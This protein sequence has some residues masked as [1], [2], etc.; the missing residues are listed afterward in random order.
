MN[1]FLKEEA[2]RHGDRIVSSV[3]LVDLKNSIEQFSQKHELNGFQ[4]WINN[5]LYNYNT[6][7]TDFV[8][9]SVICRTGS[10]ETVVDENNIESKG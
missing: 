9:K 7:R 4:K 6:N 1:N 5:S 8:A 3:H 10:I 2:S